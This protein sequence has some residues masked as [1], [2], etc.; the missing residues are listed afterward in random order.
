MI[1]NTLSMWFSHMEVIKIQFII[2]LICILL[3]K[4]EIATKISICQMTKVSDLT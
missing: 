2:W 1:S 4:L 3:E